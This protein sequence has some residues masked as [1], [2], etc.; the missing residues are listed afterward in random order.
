MGK[1]TA[2]GRLSLF[3]SV[4][5]SSAHHQLAP[6]AVAQTSPAVASAACTSCVTCGLIGVGIFIASLVGVAVIVSL[7]GAVCQLRCCK[8]M[9]RRWGCAGNDG[10]SGKKAG[11]AQLACCSFGDGGGN[12]NGNGN[13]NGGMCCA[14]S[15][16]ATPLCAIPMLLCCRVRVACVVCRGTVP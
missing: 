12:G 5:T 7:L 14:L 11:C 4:F 15:C 9:K 2:S 16:C 10:D 1:L 8:R 13:G 6:A 3:V